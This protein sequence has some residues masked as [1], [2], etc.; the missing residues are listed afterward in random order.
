MELQPSSATVSLSEWIVIIFLFAVLL[1]LPWFTA[2]LTR[3]RFLRVLSTLPGLGVFTVASTVYAIDNW[4]GSMIPSNVEAVGGGDIV[5]LFLPLGVLFFA[6]WLV[7]FL[8]VSFHGA[9][10]NKTGVSKE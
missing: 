6:F 8:F 3:S 4:A 10:R 2:R 5:F 1:L 9:T 7:V